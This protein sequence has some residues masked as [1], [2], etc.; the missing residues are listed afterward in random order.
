M[1]D[2]CVQ[3]VSLLLNK[4]NKTNWFSDIFA[5]EKS[6]RLRHISYIKHFVY[7]VE[8]TYG[9]KDEDNIKKC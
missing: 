5:L 3:R 4:L 8:N 1:C 6:I 2:K 7:Q 9:K